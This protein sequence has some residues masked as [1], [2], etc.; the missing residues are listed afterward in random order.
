MYAGKRL[1]TSSH[2]SYASQAMPAV[3]DDALAKD[4]SNDRGQRLRLLIRVQSP[5][6]YRREG[7]QT[8]RPTV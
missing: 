1:V 7:E 5:S 3:L 8:T 2:D 4:M 6:P